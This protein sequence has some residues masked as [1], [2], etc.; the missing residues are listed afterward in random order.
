MAPLSASAF[1]RL[2]D[3]T[4][5]SFYAVPRFVMH[6]D[7]AAGAAITALYREV[8]PAGGRVLDLMSS[9]VSHLP[10]DVAYARVT[11]LGMNAEEL[12]A[13]ARLDERVVHDL[14]ACPQLPWE[15]RSFEGACIALSVQYLTHPLEVFRELGRVLAPGAPLV[16]TYSDRCFPTKAV[17][18]WMR[19]DDGGRAALVE[20]YL[21]EAGGF[22]RRELIDCRPRR[23]DGD[24]LY[25]VV[26]W[27]D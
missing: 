23:W 17:A 14:N 26:G 15:A 24:P 18:L 7:D 16:I 22:A 9:W 3:S 21:E 5:T 20:H 25:A 12:A 2:D 10:H 1:A 11:G 27:R 19:L 6:V 13:N 4:D 8:L